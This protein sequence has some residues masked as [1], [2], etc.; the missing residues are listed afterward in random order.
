MSLES[1]IA[2]LFADA[3]ASYKTLVETATDAIITLENEGRIIGWNTAAER[4][5]G[6]TKEEAI[7]LPFLEKLIREEFVAVLKSEI[8]SSILSSTNRSTVTPPK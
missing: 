4:M 7:G 5:F 8:Q 1:A 6:Y 3:E 2:G